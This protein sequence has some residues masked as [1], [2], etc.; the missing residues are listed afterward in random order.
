[1][2]IDSVKPAAA[3]V[4]SQVAIRAKPSLYPE[5]FASRMRGRTKRQLGET[6]G[7]VNFGVNLTHLAPQAVSALR[8]AHSKQD[9]FVFV[10]QGTATLVTDE[11]RTR[12]GAGM[13]AGFRAG[14]GN[15][16]A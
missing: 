7:L 9:E 11:G 15:A 3:V 13:C 5:P 12:L 6:F 16:S 4:A 10:L 1:M 14:T 8:H 2:P